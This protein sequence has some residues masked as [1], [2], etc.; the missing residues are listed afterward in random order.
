MAGEEKVKRIHRVLCKLV[1]STQD[2]KVPRPG[3]SG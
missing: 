2:R 1:D 3:G